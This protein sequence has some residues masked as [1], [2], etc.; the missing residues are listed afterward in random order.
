MVVQEN[1][2]VFWIH[3]FTYKRTVKHWEP[4]VDN[5]KV[6]YSQETLKN[7]KTRVRL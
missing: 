4:E 5:E 6:F 3:V 2:H 7:W 1:N